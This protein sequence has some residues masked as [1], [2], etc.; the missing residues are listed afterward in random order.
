[1]NTFSESCSNMSG[2]GWSS[3]GSEKESRDGGST[4]TSAT[5]SRFGGNKAEP[6]T[7]GKEFGHAKRGTAQDGRRSGIWTLSSGQ[8][9]KSKASF[10][11][12]QLKQLF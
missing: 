5:P 6:S 1:M 12:Q 2:G 9:A 8:D 11:S 3:R 7:S 4:P 10:I